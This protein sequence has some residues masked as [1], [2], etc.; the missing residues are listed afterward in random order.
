M[1]KCKDCN[2]AVKLDDI[3]T[4][5]GYAECHYNPP[6]ANGG[7]EILTSRTY[8]RVN[9]ERDGCITGFVSKEANDVI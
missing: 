9:L 4:P 8:P 1:G 3:F 7:D 5:E 6:R 2:N